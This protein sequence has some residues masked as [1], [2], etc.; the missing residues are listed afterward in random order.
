MSIIRFI[1][2]TEQSGLGGVMNL[3]DGGIDK[4]FISFILDNP[5][6]FSKNYSFVIELYTNSGMS[7]QVS[8]YL[9]IAVFIAKYFL[10]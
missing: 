10:K 6:H 5:N 8:F 3:T 9:A 4:K 7:L 2:A 1:N